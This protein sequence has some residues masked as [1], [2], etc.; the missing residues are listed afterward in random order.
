MACVVLS[1]ILDADA[2]AGAWSFD[3]IFWPGWPKIDGYERNDQLFLIIL[4]IEPVN[5]QG[6][7]YCVG[8][9]EVISF[10]W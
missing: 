1:L 4:L 6:L 5:C 7:R 8:L 10:D 3:A 9:L 2:V